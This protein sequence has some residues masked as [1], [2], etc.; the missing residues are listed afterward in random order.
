M[1]SG[2]NVSHNFEFYIDTEEKI[3]VNNY[4]EQGF[5][6]SEVKVINST[7]PFASISKKIN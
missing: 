5:L 2:Y 6:D 3:V 7:F 4:S 1:K